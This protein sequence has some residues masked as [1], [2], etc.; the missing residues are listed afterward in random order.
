MAANEMQ[1][2]AQL[3]VE[4]DAATDVR[5]L[6][7]KVIA[8]TTGPTIANEMQPTDRLMVERDAVTGDETLLVKIVS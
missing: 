4:R 5:T 8:V 6:I 2:T 7:V 3:V 1:G